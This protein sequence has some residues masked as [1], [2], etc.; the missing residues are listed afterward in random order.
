MNTPVLEAWKSFNTLA[1]VALG[2]LSSEEGYD[3]M[4]EFMNDLIDSYGGDHHS[5]AGALLHVVGTLVSEWELAHPYF[6]L[7][8]VTPAQMLAHHLQARDLTQKELERESGIPQ[9]VLS[10][11]LSGKREINADHA[12]ALGKFF[13][14]NPGVFL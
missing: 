2:P 8:S 14:V 4:V 7:S 9:S 3:R 10:L 1:P 13:R 12:R 11:L 5:S 6:D